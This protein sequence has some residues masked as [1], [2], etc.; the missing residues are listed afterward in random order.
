V[1]YGRL[2]LGAVELNGPLLAVGYALLATA[3]RG[4]RAATW[5]SYAGVALLVGA[6]AVFVVICSL[7]V[8]GVR[9]GL[10]AFAIVCA[11]LAAA[12][13]GL[14]V[15]LAARRHAPLERPGWAP[16]S[17]AAATGVAV[18]GALLL[19]N[20]FRSSPRLDDVWGFWLPR[21]LA[22]RELGLDHRV[23]LPGSDILPF[24]HLD[25]PLWWSTLLSLDVRLTGSLDLRAVS[26]ELA[27]LVVAAV[28]AA[29]RLLGPYV[30][31]ALLWPGLLLVLASPELHRQAQGGGA[32]LPLA[33]YL[34]LFVLCAAL[35]LGRG[36]R[37]ALG[38]ALA[39]GAAA[40][41]IKTE[42]APQL[43]VFSAVIT[44]VAWRQRQ[45]LL[46]LWAAVAGAFALAAPFLVWRQAHGLKNDISLAHA[47]SPSFLADRTDRAATAA[48]ALG[49]QL[50][51]P[52]DWL[53]LVPLAV[54]LAVA[55][56]AL[57][58]DPR[59]LAPPALVGVGYAFWIWANWGD[60]MDLQFRLQTSGSRVVVPTVLIAGLAVPLLAER[61]AASE[62]ARRARGRGP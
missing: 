27:V 34:A 2:L 4:R 62:R 58:R 24:S 45:R 33:G 17:V 26:V 60:T 43:L 37:L 32:D 46:G 28:A 52:R 15:S 44:L 40:L 12:G 22:L 11:L 48:R 6:A 8:L 10:A 3:L 55:V 21:G 35:W 57:E 53:L 7:A 50:V 38:L 42:G 54:L 51:S 31:P 14:A 29:A 9:P 39:F 41:Q 19:A 49:H 20:A 36:D 18:V 47:L 30:R 56:A 23:F 13:G 1:S 16:V 25:Y 59:W 5:A 61:L